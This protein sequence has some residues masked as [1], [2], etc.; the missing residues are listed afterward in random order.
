MPFG[1]KTSGAMLTRAVKMQMKGI[2]PGGGLHGQLVDPHADLGGL[3]EDCRKACRTAEQVN[4]ILRPTKCILG[5][6]TI[7]FRGH[8]LGEGAIGLQNENVEKVWGAIRP[9]TKK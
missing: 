6:E 8:R 9:K 2:G 5:A 7:D 1:M 4:F 3:C